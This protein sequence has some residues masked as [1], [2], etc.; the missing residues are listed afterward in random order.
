MIEWTSLSYSTLPFPARGVCVLA[1]LLQVVPP[2]PTFF[3]LRFFNAQFSNFFPWSPFNSHFLYSHHQHLY[4]SLISQYVLTTSS[5]FPAL[6][7]YFRYVD[8]TPN[9]FVSDVSLNKS[10]STFSFL[11]HA[12]FYHALSLQSWSLPHKSSLSL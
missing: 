5:V 8:V 12:N 6:S 7:L 4:S 11:L 1:R 10:I 2:P 9:Y 3:P